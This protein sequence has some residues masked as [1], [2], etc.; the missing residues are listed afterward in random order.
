VV[1]DR[2]AEFVTVL[3]FAMVLAAGAALSVL[4]L[5]GSLRAVALIALVAAAIISWQYLRKRF[6]RL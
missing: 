2:L 3:A 4:Y 1:G 6:H 5:E